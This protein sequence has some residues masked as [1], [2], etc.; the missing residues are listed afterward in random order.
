[1]TNSDHSTYREP[2][3]LVVL[4]VKNLHFVVVLKNVVVTIN[5]YNRDPSIKTDRGIGEGST[6]EEFTVFLWVAIQL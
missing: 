1:M 5:V 3:E 4:R 2:D 6:R